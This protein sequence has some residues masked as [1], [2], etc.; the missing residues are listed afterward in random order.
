MCNTVSFLIYETPSLHHFYLLNPFLTCLAPG[1]YT[2][3]CHSLIS[4]WL[5][6]RPYQNRP[7]EGFKPSTL[8]SFTRQGR[9]FK[10]VLFYLLLTINASSRGSIV[11]FRQVTVGNLAKFV[12]KLPLC[13]QQVLYLT[14]F[15]FSEYLILN[16]N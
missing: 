12:L 1:R 4:L 8:P 9:W 14:F 10:I 13:P 11:V 6:N 15:S 7:P 16:I 2:Y 3:G 5:T